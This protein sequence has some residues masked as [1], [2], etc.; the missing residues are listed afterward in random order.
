M[1]DTLTAEIL[2]LEESLLRAETRGN[3]DYLRRVLADDF[4]EFGQSGRRYDK[5]AIIAL[6]SG[7]ETPLVVDIHDFSVQTLADSVLLATY[8]SVRRGTGQAAQ[9]SS[10]WQRHP[11][12]G[13]QL[14]F[15]Q[16]TPTSA[17]D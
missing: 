17:P 3:G 2:E 1:T 14:R 11:V 16:G 12:R 6:L 4:L 13:W 15:H 10:I 8:R 5:T 9:R 7:A